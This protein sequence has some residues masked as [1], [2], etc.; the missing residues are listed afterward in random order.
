M[1]GGSVLAVVRTGSRDVRAGNGSP[2]V[3]GVRDGGPE[4]ARATGSV[5]FLS[6]GRGARIPPTAEII[7]PYLSRFPVSGAKTK[8]REL[9]LNENAEV[10][11]SVESKVVPVSERIAFT[12]VDDLGPVK[13]SFTSKLLLGLFVDG[14]TKFVFHIKSAGGYPG[15]V[16]NLPFPD[17]LP[18]ALPPPSE[19]LVVFLLW[20]HWDALDLDLLCKATG[21]IFC[22]FF[23]ES[24]NLFGGRLN[25]LMESTKG[26]VIIVPSSLVNDK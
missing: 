16:G 7:Y 21:G 24:S 18:R 22:K 25:R 15:L 8:P 4:A 5:L 23:S 19:V 11:L 26:L 1:I 10:L 12:V 6:L 13:V 2:C 3:L 14:M 17:R 9:K 20:L